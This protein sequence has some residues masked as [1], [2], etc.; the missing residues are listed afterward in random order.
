MS[1][2]KTG[3]RKVISRVRIEAERPERASFKMI[4]EQVGLTKD[5]QPRF[6]LRTDIR[7]RMRS[8]GKVWRANPRA[9][10]EMIRRR[11]GRVKSTL[12]EDQ[13]KTG[14]VSKREGD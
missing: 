14:I 9:I 11:A 5:G 2:G 4:C 10:R 8:V 12:V 1:R 6:K 7:L 3:A 13:T